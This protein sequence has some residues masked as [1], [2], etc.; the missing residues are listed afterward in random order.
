[1]HGHI[2]VHEGPLLETSSLKGKVRMICTVREDYPAVDN[3]REDLDDVYPPQYKR[4]H[5]YILW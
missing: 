1:M 4:M 5:C 2:T 3:V